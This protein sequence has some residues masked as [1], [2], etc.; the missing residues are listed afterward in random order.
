MELGIYPGGNQRKEKS[1]FRDQLEGFLLKKKCKSI[2]FK[3]F[4]F[5]VW[6]VFT[7]LQWSDVVEWLSSFE[8]CYLMCWMPIGCPL[9]FE[10][11]LLV[12]FEDFGRIKG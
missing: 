4:F 8:I 12:C 3:R 5:F 11:I 10:Q 7:A 9:H 2:T 1:C 6:G